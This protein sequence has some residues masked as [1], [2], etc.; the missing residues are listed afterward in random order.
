MKENGTTSKHELHFTDETIKQIGDQIINRVIE[1]LSDFI[2]SGLQDGLIPNHLARD[3]ANTIIQS[4][5]EK[6]TS[7]T[8]IEIAILKARGKLHKSLSQYVYKE[9]PERI[10]QHGKDKYG[11]IL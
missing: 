5:E 6:E 8:K 10:Q 9:L 4:E 2:Q 11:E 3:I 7:F 1:N